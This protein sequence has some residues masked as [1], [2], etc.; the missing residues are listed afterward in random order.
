[1]TAVIKAPL[2]VKQFGL[3]ITQVTIW[4]DSKIVVNGFCKGKTHTL[5]SM[6]VTDWEEI[7]EQAEAI[8]E[9]GTSV[10]IK[11]VKAH[12]SDEAQASKE[13]QNGN[14]QA[15]RLADLGDKLSAN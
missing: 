7:W 1:M 15:D 12:T 3:G 4:P 2:A 5:Q 6:L 13:L 9:R 10:Q 14:W 11:N 8:L